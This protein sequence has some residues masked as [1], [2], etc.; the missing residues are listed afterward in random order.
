MPAEKVQLSEILALLHQGKS[1]QEIADILSERHH[2]DYKRSSVSAR[3]ARAGKSKPLKQ[4]DEEMPWQVRLEHHTAYPARML[5]LMG[6]RRSGKKNT[7]ANDKR[8]DGWLA[9]M[10]RD[11]TVVVYLPDSPDGFHFIPGE[12][13]APD[14][15][16]KRD[17]PPEA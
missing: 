8:L 10:K 4:Y 3:I 13:D 11:G 7:P 15:P 1:H 12:W 5:R 6:R 2:V 16:I 14:L 17:F 9:R